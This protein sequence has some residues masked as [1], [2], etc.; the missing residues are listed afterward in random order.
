M[1]RAKPKGPNLLDLIPVQSVGWERKEDGTVFLKKPKV[2]NRLLKKIIER[3][4][5]ST[6]YKIHLDDFGSFVWER[7][8]GNTRVEEIGVSLKHEFGEKV[9]P[10]YERLCAFVKIMAY[11]KFINYKN[12][13]QCQ[14]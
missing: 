14:H 5:K 4:G 1:A 2:Q 12:V 11:Q 8:D 9:E 3:M 6:H 7:C 10:V 13:T